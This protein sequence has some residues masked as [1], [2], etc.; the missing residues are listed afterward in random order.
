MV[1]PSGLFII[2][3]IAFCLCRMGIDSTPMEGIEPEFDAF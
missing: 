2:R 3:S 1:G